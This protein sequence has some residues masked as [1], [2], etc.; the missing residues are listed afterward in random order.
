MK[1]VSS[2]AVAEVRT[3]SGVAAKPLVG[4]IVAFLNDVAGDHAATVADRRLPGQCDRCLD[5]VAEVQVQR[6]AWPLCSHNKKTTKDIRLSDGFYRHKNKHSNRLFSHTDRIHD[7]DGAGGSAGPADAGLV[8]GSDSEDV[9]LV[10]HH[11]I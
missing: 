3:Q 2:Y 8:L 11:I 5:L 6:W 1:A 4:A 7:L 9:L 10:L